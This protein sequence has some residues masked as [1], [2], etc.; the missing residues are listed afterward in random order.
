MGY[1]PVTD[2]ASYRPR[3]VVYRGVGEGYCSLCGT[4]SESLAKAHDVF[5]RTLYVC[6]G[7]LRRNPALTEI[8]SRGGAGDD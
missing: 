8:E 7:C 2:L 5:G 3:P 6:Q 4:A 1:Y